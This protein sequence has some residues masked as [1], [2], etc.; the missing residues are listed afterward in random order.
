MNGHGRPVLAGEHGND[1][2][3]T[4][5][6]AN[7][8]YNDYRHGHQYSASSRGGFGDR[9]DNGHGYANYSSYGSY[10]DRNN[11]R[12]NNGNDI[13]TNYIWGKK[14]R[15]EVRL[16]ELREF[17]EQAG[18]V[19]YVEIM[20]MPGGRSKGCGVVEYKEADDAA[21]AI[22]QLHDLPLLGRPAFIREDRETD[23]PRPPPAEVEPAVEREILLT[24]LPDKINWHHIK[25]L[26]KNVG[27][28]E[29]ADIHTDVAGNPDGTATI[30]MASIADA[31]EAI[32]VYDG[33]E[34]YGKVIG[35]SPVRSKGASEFTSTTSHY[36]GTT[37]A[38]STSFPNTGRVYTSRSRSRS[39]GFVRND[40]RR[41]G[42]GYPGRSSSRGRSRS[43]SVYRGRH[44]YKPMEP[45][46][47]MPPT[48][49][50]EKGYDTHTPSHPT[51]TGYSNYSTSS[52]SVP[53][54]SSSRPPFNSSNSYGAPSNSMGPPPLVPNPGLFVRNLPYLTTN[55]DLIELFRTC[56]NIVHAE[57]LMPHGTPRGCGIVRFDCVESAER[58]I[59]KL[60]GYVYG[61]RALELRYDRYN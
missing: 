27:R 39:P 21:Q 9:R 38:P 8:R 40:Y 14:S 31:Q 25:D 61:G 15:H 45:S 7:Q 35:V 47:S 57:I 19:V 37:G 26:L 10:R 56:G 59:S 4:M 30:L 43:P 22:R 5:G 34:W 44:D 23:E 54:S 12:S 2:Y 55:N 13:L 24:N 53:Y 20:T 46:S 60:S 32:R 28:I 16:E 18:E 49:H 29:H 58:A 48:R 50:N 52:P 33:Y 1:A 6:H 51:S 41:D 3:T 42:Y 11:S 36:P 17:M